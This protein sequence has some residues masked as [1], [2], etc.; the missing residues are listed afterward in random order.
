MSE[1]AAFEVHHYGNREGLATVTVTL[2]NGVRS[3]PI[4]L[5]ADEAEV[6]ESLRKQAERLG[7][8]V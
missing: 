3:K 6:L 8:W 4:E 1:I 2:P 7:S 5:S